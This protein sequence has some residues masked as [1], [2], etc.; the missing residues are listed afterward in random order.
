[1]DTAGGGSE[2]DFA[3]V[4]VLDVGTGMQCAELQERLRP[5][6]LAV[7]CLELAREYGDALMAVERNNHGSAVLAL[8]EA[9]PGVRLFRQSGQAGWLTSAASKPEVVAR[10]GALLQQETRRFMSRR[11]LG[12]CRTFVR[13][14][15]GHTGAA[16]GAHDD[17]VM[18]MAIA[19]A[20]RAEVVAKG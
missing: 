15:R 3:A 5:A 9:V 2:G 4:Q 7:L 10:L 18:S 13:D 1:V 19:Q 6:E 16:S 17:L 14:E 8:L 11:L 20:V 12:E